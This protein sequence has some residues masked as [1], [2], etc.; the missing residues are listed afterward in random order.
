MQPLRLRSTPLE[1]GE[2]VYLIGWSYADEGRQ[3]VHEGRFVGVEEG[4]VNEGSLLMSFDM[5]A[6]ANLAGISGSPVIDANGYVVGL[7]S[8]KSTE[9]FRIA[10]ATYALDALETRKEPS[11]E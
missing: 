7:M 11:R 8:A 10:P 5:P 1:A 2:A 6:N 9:F 4:S 3:R